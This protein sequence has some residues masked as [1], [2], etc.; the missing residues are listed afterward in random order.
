MKQAEEDGEAEI[1]IDISALLLFP[2]FLVQFFSLHHRLVQ[3]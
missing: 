3:P 2:S 1:G